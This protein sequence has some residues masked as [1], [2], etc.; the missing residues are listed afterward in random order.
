MFLRRRFTLGRAREEELA[1]M[2][3]KPIGDRIGF[4]HPDPSRLLALVYDR[5]VNAGRTEAPPSSFHP[6]GKP[7]K[8]RSDSGARWR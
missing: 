2:I 7:K 8:K 3:A 1:N 5:A 4:R 6:R